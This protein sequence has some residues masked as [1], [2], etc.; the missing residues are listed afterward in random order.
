MDTINLKVK[1]LTRIQIAHPCIWTGLTETNNK[2]EIHYINNLLHVIVN[3]KLI[4]NKIVTN[5]TPLNA[6][7]DFMTTEDMLEITGII[8]LKENWREI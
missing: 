6:L 7:D 4:L 5:Y 8:E 3:N 1:N 2:V